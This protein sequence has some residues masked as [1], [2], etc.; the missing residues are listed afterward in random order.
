MLPSRRF[1]WLILHPGTLGDVLLARPAIHALR[2]DY[3]QSEVALLAA[4]AVGEFLLECGEIDRLF[5]L[6]GAYMAGLYA[7]LSF[8]DGEF[9]T[10][11]TRCE[12]VIG[13]L[14]DDDGAIEATLRRAGVG[15]IR[16]RSPMGDDL[17]STHQAERYLETMDMASSQPNWSKALAPPKPALD[18]GRSVLDRLGVLDRGQLVVIHPGSGSRHKCLDPSRLAG[19]VDALVCHGRTPVLLEGPADRCQVAAV[20]QRCHAAVRVVRDLDLQTAA[21][22]LCQAILYVGHDSGITHLAAALAVPTIACFGPTDPRRWRPLGRSVV[23][24][25]GPACTCHTWEGVQQCHAK[26]CLH[27]SVNCIVKVSL[28][29]L[30]TPIGCQG[31]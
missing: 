12:G 6:E 5:P 13:W 15:H 22:I 2:R 3:P 20:Q 1:Q 25:Q 27:V 11:L 28:D 7:G 8:L 10:W 18:A 24:L 31:S 17:R 26:P 14:R 29:L 23:V 21:G 19:L 4:H 16:M 30:S 9:R